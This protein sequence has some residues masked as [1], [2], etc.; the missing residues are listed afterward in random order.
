MISYLLPTRN[1]PGTLRATLET[2]GRLEPDA[3][4]AVGG[5][6]VVVV[7]N[8]S[9]PSVVVPETL[10]NG[11]PVEL[12]RRE[13][14]EGA[15]ARNAGAK[16]A[17]GEWVIMLDDD[18]YPLDAGH[19]AL[20]AAAPDG[21]VAIG[22]EIDL[23]DGSR[24]VGGLPE[25]I[26]GC[27]A[28]IRREAFLEVGGYDPDFDFYGEEYDLCARLL[29]AGWRVVHHRRFRVL[30]EKVA[31]GRNHDLILCNL[32]RNNGWVAQRYA[33]PDRRNDELCEVIAR[34]GR[35]AQREG[36]EAGYLKGLGELFA[37]MDR[38][39][40]R[41]MSPALFDR[42]TGLAHARAALAR[43][44]ELV[45]TRQVALVEVDKN[46]WAVRRAL[47]ELDI[48]ILTNES[49]ADAIVVGTLSPGPILDALD[50]HRGA[51]KPVV[52]P[53]TPLEKAWTEYTTV[54]LL[55]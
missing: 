7:D 53:W 21:V 45:D 10:A 6:Q 31:A 39:V 40:R 5:A 30:H 9:E 49:R 25:V 37:A 16:A 48:E 8:A 28:A 41:E 32:V 29:L 4:E 19:V 46:A 33:P 2:I 1:R 22:A 47:V 35:I 52:A 3:H 44:P 34:Y 43:A 23:P 26:V 11:F 13:T 17:R 18:S 14:N 55:Q 20:I 51:D 54:E 42:F 12:V 38:Q 27:G 36:A 50:R 15:S 24:E